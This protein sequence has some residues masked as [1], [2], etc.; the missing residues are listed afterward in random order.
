[1][2][3]FIVLWWCSVKAKSCWSFFKFLQLEIGWCTSIAIFEYCTY[4]T[5]RN[6]PVLVLLFS[7]QKQGF[8]ICSYDFQINRNFVLL[9]ILWQ[10]FVYSSSIM[11]MMDFVSI[12]DFLCYWRYDYFC[13]VCNMYHVKS[14][15]SSC[16]L[17]YEVMLSFLILLQYH[18]TELTHPCS[19]VFI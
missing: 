1:M 13:S 10:K 4:S 11:V 15:L 6:I 14:N 19:Y 16:L 7:C 8:V 17:Q 2:H 5:V 18:H 9:T 3:C 12:L